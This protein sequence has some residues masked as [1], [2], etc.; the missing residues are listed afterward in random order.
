MLKPIHLMSPEEKAEL[1]ARM[2]AKGYYDDDF[3][4]ILGNLNS[5]LGALPDRSRKPAARKAAARKKAKASS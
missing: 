1:V 3:V 4:G 5:I 2:K